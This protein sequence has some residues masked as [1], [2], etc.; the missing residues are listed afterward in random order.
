MAGK[1]AEKIK[2]YLIISLSIIFVVSFYFRFIHAKMKDN[3]VSPKTSPQ[4]SALPKLLLPKLT[5]SSLRE[6]ENL[7]TLFKDNDLQAIRDIFFPLTEAATNTAPVEKPTE[8]ELIINEPSMIL[9]GT[10]V[11]KNSSI[12]IIDNQFL[13]EGDQIGEFF[14]EDIGKK[15]VLLSSGDR[16]IRLEILKNE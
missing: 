5:N 3:R 13:R 7:D 9:K 16:I 8:P 10:I 15:D 6:V 12:A 2:L 1:G 14:V 11:G 4:L